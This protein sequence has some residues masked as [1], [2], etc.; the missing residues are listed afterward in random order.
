MKRTEGAGH[1]NNRF[2]TEDVQAGRPPTELTA[3]WFNDVQEEIC[4][5]IEAA[6]GEVNGESQQQ[7]KDAIETLIATLTAAKTDKSAA[8]H[9]AMPSDQYVNLTLGPNE[10][11]YTAPADGYF[12]YYA[13]ADRDWGDMSFINTT[14]GLTSCIGRGPVGGGIRCSLPCRESDQITVLYVGNPTVKHFRFYY[15]EGSKQ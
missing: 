7:L 15:A 6:G 11:R 13:L 10:S 14:S 5:V 1:V 4:S 3:E 8:A 2:V 12:S 9:A